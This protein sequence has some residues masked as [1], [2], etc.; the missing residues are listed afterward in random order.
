MSRTAE[1]PDMSDYIV[2][3][4][5]DGD[6]KS[7]DGILLSILGDRV[8]KPGPS[9]FGAARNVEEV[10]ESQRAVCFSEIPLGMLGRL[11]QR[12]S[13]HGLGF[14]KDFIISKGGGP[15]WY[16]EKGSPRHTALEQL[17]ST[18]R[19]KGPDHPL[20]QLTPFIDLPG[21]YGK[22]SYRF[23]WEREWRHV[24]KLKFDVSEVAFL[25]L[26]EKLHNTA[27]SFF[28]DAEHTNLGP[29]YPCAFLDP[30]WPASKA[31]AVL[32][33]HVDRPVTDK[34]GWPL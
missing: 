33:T 15:I 31:E 1:W 22:S 34:F 17:K 12:R 32:E 18:A 10:R 16:V 13:K 3:F 9:P 14:R 23:E 5:Q 21:E 7:A 29:N 25:F 8:L 28:A 19:Q 20:W 2:H 26:P 4:P 24:G 30:T 27:R 6:P 11:V